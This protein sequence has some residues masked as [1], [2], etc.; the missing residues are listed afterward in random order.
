MANN[1]NNNYNRNGTIDRDGNNPNDSS[2]GRI[3]LEDSVMGVKR[4]KVEK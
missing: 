3:G 1:N 2:R 4:I